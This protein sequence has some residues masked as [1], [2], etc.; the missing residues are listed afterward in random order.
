MKK[1]CGLIIGEG[2]NM[3]TKMMFIIR[4]NGDGLSALEPA[5]LYDVAQWF[6]DNYPEGIYTG[7]SGKGSMAVAEIRDRC[8]E[9]IAMHKGERGK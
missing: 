9:L 8:K 5:S 7:C 2:I 3:G 6:I 4:S 1:I